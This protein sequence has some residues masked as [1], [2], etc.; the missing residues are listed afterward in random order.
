MLCWDDLRYFLAV[1]RTGTTLAAA[2]SLKVSQT[3][4]ARRVTALEE[5]LGLILFERRQSGYALTSAG[6]SL[7]AEAEAVERAAH[8]FEAA[9]AADKREIAGVVRLSSVEIYSATV[10]PPLMKELRDR[11]PGIRIELD[12]TEVKRDLGGGEA[13]IALRGGH[14]PDDA[15]LVGRRIARDPWTVYCSRA[16]AE[17]NGLPTTMAELAR[18]P[19]IGGGGDYVWPMYRKWLQ[20]HGLEDAVVLEHGTTSGLL[21]AVRAGLGMA[22]LPSF[23]AD[24]DPELVQVVVPPES[25]RME[26]WLVTH[27]R[28]RHL[29]RI[30][31]VMDFLGE[32]LQRM[33]KERL[34]AQPGAFAA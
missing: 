22:V 23:M 21:S 28:V 3:T 33:A 4:A 27:E 7:L 13:D 6:D 26:L 8:A 30:R 19:I 31:A 9:A 16:Y 34:A 24:R 17:A 15:G 25:D 1:A 12:S 14:P 10:L 5:A 29:P 2:R 32:R 18:H 20:H 11:H